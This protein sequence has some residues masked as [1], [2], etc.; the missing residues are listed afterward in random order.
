[1]LVWG[2]LTVEKNAALLSNWRYLTLSQPQ[3]T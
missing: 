3:G 2:D 1:M